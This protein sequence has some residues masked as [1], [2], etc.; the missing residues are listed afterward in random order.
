[1][2]HFRM[3]AMNIDM[4]SEI[5]ESSSNSRLVYSAHFHV[6]AFVKDLNL[7]LL[8]PARDYIT[9]STKLFSLE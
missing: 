3:I 5:G 8:P 6:N 9:N 7:F 2:Q 1:M 4:Q